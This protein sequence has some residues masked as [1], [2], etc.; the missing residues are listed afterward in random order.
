MNY[1]MQKELQKKQDLEKGT[2]Y[3]LEDGDWRDPRTGD[4][5]DRDGK[6]KR[7]KLGNKFK[8]CP[9]PTSKYDSLV[10]EAKKKYP[11]KADKTEKH[12]ITPKYLGGDPDGPTVDLNAA[13][14]QEITNEFRKEWPY[15][16]DRPSPSER[17][18]I[19]EEVYTKFPLPPDN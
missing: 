19:M 5:Y 18:K 11:K 4:I 15:G 3:Y 12:H 2:G 6:L 14:H 16:E 7:D 13:Y 10:E 17:E 9:K 1:R 8:Q